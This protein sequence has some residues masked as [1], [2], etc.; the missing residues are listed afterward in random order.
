MTNTSLIRSAAT[1]YK[2]WDNIPGIYDGL[3]KAIEGGMEMM[4]EGLTGLK[5]E[6]IIDERLKGKFNELATDIY[7]N[8]DGSF[9]TDVDYKH[10]IQE[11]ESMEQ[12]YY[13]ALKSN[14]PELLTEAKLK[15]NNLDSEIQTTKELRKSITDPEFGMSNAVKGSNRLIVNTWLAE[16]YE[17][18][19]E[20]GNYTY[21]MDI[22]GLG[23]VTKTRQEIEA[24][25]LMKNNLPNEAY[26]KVFRKY[27]GTKKAGNTEL[28]AYDLGQNVVPTKKNDLDV[29]LNDEGFAAGGTF[30]DLMMKPNNKKYYSELYGGIIKS[31]D[32]NPTEDDYDEFVDAIAN[33]NNKFWQTQP[34]GS[35]EETSRQIAIET[36]TNAVVNG[37]NETWGVGEEKGENIDDIG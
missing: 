6:K 34:K 3:D 24:M 7:D 35:W 32:M 37:H 33:P 21:T 27:I 5:K 18:S 15:F 4:E 9:K 30:T 10:T 16:N 1:A 31:Y 22:P 26:T 11:V 29:F 17:K 2:N 12:E 28:L 19:G 13:D 8:Y 20:G 14:D 36:L 23:K 25:A